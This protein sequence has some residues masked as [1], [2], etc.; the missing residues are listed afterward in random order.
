M[1]V[2]Y[3]R[4]LIFIGWPCKLNFYSTNTEIKMPSAKSPYKPMKYVQLKK[5]TIATN[6]MPIRLG[7]L[8]VCLLLFRAI[9]V[10]IVIK[11]A[12]AAIL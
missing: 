8:S 4:P 6:I 10:E 12:W 9:R 11:V 5:D 7:L 2:L 3:I 1:V